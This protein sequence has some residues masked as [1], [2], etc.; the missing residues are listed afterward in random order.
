ME[1]STV[2]DGVRPLGDDTHTP[3]AAWR[4]F[5]DAV[6]A[7]RERRV[8][9]RARYTLGDAHDA[10]LLDA[11]A[12]LRFDV[13]QRVEQTRMLRAAGDA[14]GR[15]VYARRMFEDS[16]RGAVVVLSAS[17]MESG[18]GTLELLDSFH[19]EAT[20][21]FH[22]TSRAGDAAADVMDAFLS[23]LLA[24]FL[25]E[26]FNC[27]ASVTADGGARFSLKLGVGRDANRTVSR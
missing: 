23:A 12:G 8:A 27:D 10:Q 4:A 16:F 11:L 20:T 17:L 18:F 19:R 5:T 21:R 3:H 14:L 6:A 2:V 15:N 26:A 25:G 9:Q 7:L 22:P 13:A 24:G 1:P